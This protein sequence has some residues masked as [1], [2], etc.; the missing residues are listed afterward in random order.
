VNCAGCGITCDTAHSHDA[1]CN[2]TSCTY[3]G[4]NPGYG[5]C[6]A[7][8][9][10]SNGCETPV[11]TTTNCTGCGIACDTAH[12]RDAGC[13]GGTCTYG[14]CNPGYE[15]CDGGAPNSNGCETP[16]TTAANCGGCGVA[17]GSQHAADAGCTGTACTYTCAAGWANCDTVAPNTAGCECNTPSC[18]GDAGAGSCQTT[19][20]NGNNQPFYDCLPLL[21]AT[22]P[23]ATAQE[24]A[25]EACASYTGSQSLCT[26]YPCSPSTMGPIVCSLTNN[27]CFC[28]AFSGT[29]I[30][31]VDN[32]DGTPGDCYCPST[33]PTI[34]DR[35]WN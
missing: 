31:Y 20:S 10:N 35:K 7:A 8:A 33:N 18:C 1:G 30:G 16:T 9:P 21:T 3:G 6:D 29:N 11:D 19:H 32:G 28:W 14:G 17:C 26:Q 24:L 15:D 25:F 5:D 27:S 22:T 2:G 23:F 34:G 13:N 12:S 4:C